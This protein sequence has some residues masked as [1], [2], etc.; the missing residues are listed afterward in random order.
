LVG[1]WAVGNYPVLVPARNESALS[2]TASS[3]AATRPALIALLVMAVIGVPLM[4][5]YT[6][7]V[8]RLFRG[9]STT[10]GGGSG[11]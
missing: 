3:A 7:V 4:L 11:Y 1:I 5:A 2:L 9:R 6:M 8:Y 10:D